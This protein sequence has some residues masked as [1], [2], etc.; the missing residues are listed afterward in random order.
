M[1]VRTDILFQII[2]QCRCKDICEIWYW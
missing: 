2:M 1:Y